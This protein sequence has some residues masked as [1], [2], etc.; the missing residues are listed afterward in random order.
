MMMRFAWQLGMVPV[1][2]HALDRAIDLNAV[3]IEQNQF[4]FQIGRVLASGEDA[5][6]KLIPTSAGFEKS[7]T[8]IVNHRAKF[9]VDY[10]SLRWSNRYRRK[11][12]KLSAKENAFG[13]EQVSIAAARSLFKL[14]SYKDEYE[15]ARLHTQTGFKEKLN[16]WFEGDYSIQY[17]LAPPLL[18]SAK[19]A[20]GRPKK[21]A[22]SKGM[23]SGFNALTKMKW[24]RGSFADP[25]G[26][27]AERKM[28]RQLIGWFDELVKK[29]SEELNSDNVNVW[30]D[31]MS[32]PMGIKGYGPVKE[33]SVVRVKRQIDTLLEAT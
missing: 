11:I 32:A 13:S 19:D 30:H 31:I 6:Q 27:T 9:L 29:C 33:E 26:W 18:S 3:E 21:R 17:H 20:R 7:L 2:L 12:D 22:M 28:E 16:E 25:F 4:A 23:D 10:Q 24:L 8:G 14:M 1:S 15:V 5:Q